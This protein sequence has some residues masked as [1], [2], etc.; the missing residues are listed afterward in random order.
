MIFTRSERIGFGGGGFC[1]DNVC[2]PFG[3]I[4][5]LDCLEFWIIFCKSVSKSSS[6]SEAMSAQVFLAN[7]GSLVRPIS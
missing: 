3:L 4:S 2:F 1:W 6:D 5:I 7:F